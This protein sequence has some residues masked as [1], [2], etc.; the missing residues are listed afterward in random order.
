MVDD[1]GANVGV[2][3]REGHTPESDAQDDSVASTATPAAALSRAEQWVVDSGS[4][5]WVESQ[6]L[7]P[8]EALADRV[9]A[10]RRESADLERI[11]AAAR[12]QARKDVVEE[13]AEMVARYQAD[14]SELRAR[15]GRAGL[16]VAEAL[17]AQ[18]IATDDA[19]LAPM[20]ARALRGQSEVQRVRVATGMGSAAEC[21]CA[22]HALGVSV[23]EDPT[24]SLGDV[25]V[26]LPHGRADRRVGTLLAL[27]SDDMDA[28]LAHD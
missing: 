14:W 3:K 8:L 19:G 7:A 10:L 20:L 24:L 4:A 21:F 23:L 22:E 13:Q 16:R 25:I 6:Q 28:E 1:D 9:A 27:V 18:H 15:A 2:T 5:Q 26:E 17:V 11:L 12:A